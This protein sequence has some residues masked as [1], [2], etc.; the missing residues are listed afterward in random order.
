MK[1]LWSLMLIF[2]AM[3]ACST[4]DSV[5]TYWVNGTQ[6]DCMGVA[7]RKCLQVQ[8]GKELDAQVWQNFFAKIEGFDYEPGFIYKLKVKEEPIPMEQVPAD[9]SSIKYTLVKVLEKTPDTRFAIDGDWTLIRLDAA[10]LNRM[11]PAPKLSINLIDMQISG[12]GGCNNYTAGI[13]GITSTTISFGVIAG[14]QRACIDP[15]MEH[16]YFI[17]LNK[18]KT[19]ALENDKLICYD[20]NSNEI[21]A[22]FR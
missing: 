5:S 1:N 9:G 21:L 10:P 8:K 4:D 17:A 14:G 3:T 7:P 12:S 2:I 18:V 16:A 15:N 11:V 22:F 19:Y 13:K 20:E 6:V